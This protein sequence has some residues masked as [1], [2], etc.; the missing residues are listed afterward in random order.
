MEVET[1]RYVDFDGHW[2]IFDGNVQELSADIYMRWDESPNSDTPKLPLQILALPE[3]PETAPSIDVI[4]LYPENA[5]SKMYRIGDTGE[6]KDYTSQ[7]SIDYNTRVYARTQYQDGTWSDI[8]S[9]TITNVFK[10]LE[11]GDIQDYVP[12][13]QEALDSSG[14]TVTIP[15]GFKVASDSGQTVA[16]GI[17]I[18]DRNANQF[19]W[20]PVGNYIAKDGQEKENKIARR[21]FT[22]TT[23]TTVASG[24]SITVSYPF[25]GEEDS[26]SILA[27]QEEKYQI[28]YFLSSAQAN[29]GFYIGRYEQGVGNIIRQGQSVETTLTRDESLEA[30]KSMYGASS[31][32]VSSLINSYAWD[33]ALNF[34]CQN[35]APGY[36][37]ATAQD[38]KYANVGT[39]KPAKTG[40]YQ[41]NGV[42]V[43]RYSNLFDFLGNY[44][45]M[46][47]EGVYYLYAFR[48]TCRGGSLSSIDKYNFQYVSYRSVL[49]LDQTG[50]AYRTVLYLT[51]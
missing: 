14:N 48:G 39:Y 43:D 13:T 46:T 44:R 9:Y 34:I 10:Q 21:T 17:V 40:E 42:V 51:K 19:V 29:K 4:I 12:K 22:S 27:T 41:Y 2:Y 33:T 31:S 37:L 15:E 35:N 49:E 6:W 1:G 5:L 24:A 45:E 23:S 26:R 11:I 28:D 8:I 36:T 3:P 32:V 25:F 16:D 50:N 20:I 38:A 47:T 18:E 30:C 7:L